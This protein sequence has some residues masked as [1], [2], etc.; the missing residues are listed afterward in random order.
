MSDNG[1]NSA[2]FVHKFQTKNNNYIYCLNTNRI[3]EVNNVVYQIIDDYNV[4]TNDNIMN[5]FKNIYKKQEIQNA[6]NAIE[7]I[8]TKTGAFGSRIAENFKIAMSEEEYEYEI[9]NKIG[10]IT[11]NVTENCNLRC[12]YCSYDKN[13]S[14]N[15]SHSNKMMTWDTAKAAIDFLKPRHKE[16]KT[17]GIGWYGGEPFLNFDIMKRSLDY[18]IETINIENNDIFTVNLTTNATVLNKEKIK[19]LCDNNVHVLISLDG[20]QLMHDRY[21]KYKNGKGSYNEVIRNLESIKN[22]DEKYFNRHISINTVMSPPFRFMQLYEYFKNSKLFSK[23]VIRMNFINSLESR[24]FLNQFSEIDKQINSDYCFLFNVFKENIIKEKY[25][26]NVNSEKSLLK[27]MFMR[28]FYCIANRSISPPIQS[29][30]LLPCRI[31]VEKLFVNVDGKLFPCSNMN[32]KITEYCIGDVINGFYRDNGNTIAYQKMK[33]ITELVNI[34]CADCWANR[35]CDKC[36]FTSMLPTKS[37]TLEYLQKYCYGKR[38]YIHE[39]LQEYFIIEEHN[40]DALQSLK[41]N[42]NGRRFEL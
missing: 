2:P 9:N 41:T 21:R 7:E 37:D 13:N 35:L 36:C 23:N 26:G 22:T 12:S 33:E 32:E 27:N 3:F 19:W 16:T 29:I 5:K 4:I 18:F 11:L 15:R 6:I 31:G 38:Q 24:E 39:M 28:G 42:L 20:P 8:R 14:F 34:L 25:D 30:P 17:K 40:P 1:N 10:T